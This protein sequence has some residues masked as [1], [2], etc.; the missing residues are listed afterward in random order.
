MIVMMGSYYDPNNYGDDA[1]SARMFQYEARIFQDNET[2]SYS[3]IT[4]TKQFLDS[5]ENRFSLG[6]FSKQK[7]FFTFP[8]KLLIESYSKQP[9]DNETLMIEFYATDKVV[10]HKRVIYG[11][12]DFL[13]DLGG[14]REALMSIG[15]TLL[16][17]SEFLYGN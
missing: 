7:T 2:L 13:G 1:V 9:K 17:L 16:Y 4:I 12:L 14:L 15:S 3:Q 10:E 6:V 5:T 11:L 8:E